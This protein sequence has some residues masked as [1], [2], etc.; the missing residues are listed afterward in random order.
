MSEEK[1]GIIKKALKRVFVVASV[2]LNVVIILVEIFTEIIPKKF[3]LVAIFCAV[4]LFLMSI[5]IGMYIESKKL[6]RDEPHP[7]GEIENHLSYV[8]IEYAI[9]ELI[10]DVKETAFYPPHIIIGIDRG[11]AI[12][13]GI[14]SKNLYLPLATMTSSEKWTISNPVLSLDDGIKNPPK[15]TEKYKDINKI[16]L[17]DDAC[18]TG[19]TLKKAYDALMKYGFEIKTATILNEEKELG[20]GK[21][22]KPDF[23]IYK[24]TKLNIRMPWDL[25]KEVKEK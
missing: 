24:T 8:D 10:K 7:R 20:P 18:R 16:L 3:F 2:L 25:A 1:N 17:V 9:K 11:G 15:R 5:I 19:W 4:I 23:S 12:T 13:G 22:I 6:R 14:L 21:F